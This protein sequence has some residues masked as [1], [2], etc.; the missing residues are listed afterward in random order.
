VPAHPTP[1]ELSEYAFRPETA[2][3]G[4]REHTASCAACAAEIADLRTV[5]ATLAEL[6]E[7]ELPAEVG[8]RLDAAIAR[9]WQEADADAEKQQHAAAG[10]SAPR[11]GHRLSWGRIARPVGALGVLAL[12]GAGI[13]LAVSQGPESSSS[14]ASGAAAPDA[15]GASGDVALAQWVR[16]V[17]P[18]TSASGPVGTPAKIPQHGQGT[19]PDATHAS[20]TGYPQRAGYTV[21]AAAEK[22]FDGEPA[23]LVVYQN[24]AR[25][26][27]PTV[28]A[29]VYAGPCPT[30][31]S[32]ILDQGVV[33]R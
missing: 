19:S 26:A 18:V 3:A 9:A 21:L 7:P 2:A 24:S 12:A 4:L 8:I 15:T 1:E 14:G 16:T 20:C 33:S 32:Q 11:K 10:A 29:V 23:T 17:L 22:Q 13:G 25:P 28:L 6:P 5:L 27:S 31:S 30:V